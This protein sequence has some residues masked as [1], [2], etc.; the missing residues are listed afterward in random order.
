MYTKDSFE[1]K[2]ESVSMV[3]PKARSQSKGGCNQ[4]K[5]VSSL[6]MCAPLFQKLAVIETNGLLARSGNQ[7]RANW[8][9][10]IQ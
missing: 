4:L 5:S 9:K 7:E 6:T 8:N 3:T 1:F 2:L 10:S